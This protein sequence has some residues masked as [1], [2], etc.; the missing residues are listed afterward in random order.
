MQWM[1]KLCT[2]II[3]TL[4]S[5]NINTCC[6]FNCV[7]VCPSCRRGDTRSSSLQRWSLFLW[8]SCVRRS[9][10]SWRT[11]R[12]CRCPKEVRTSNRSSN[13]PPWTTPSWTWETR[14]TSCPSLT[15]CCRSLWRCDW[16]DKHWKFIV[17]WGFFPL[18]FRPNTSFCL[19]PLLVFSDCDRGGSG[20][21]VCGSEPDCL[22]HHG[23]GGRR[24]AADGPGWSLQTTVSSAQTS[25]CSDTCDNFLFLLL[26]VSSGVSLKK[27]Q[28]QTTE[29]HCYLELSYRCHRF[30]PCWKHL[31]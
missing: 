28:R 12:V 4:W 2:Y 6:C 21:E 7:S 10:C 27:L 19:N 5:S 3:L 18:L 16:S 29:T 24:E 23:G 26:H 1:W 31:W 30:E 13:A 11:W 9:T 8:R 22:L 15:W 25:W 14:E 20:S 17:F